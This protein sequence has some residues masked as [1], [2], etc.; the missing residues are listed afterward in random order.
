[1][2]PHVWHAWFTSVYTSSFAGAQS[3]IFQS[4]GGF[5]ESGHFDKYFVKKAQGKESIL[6]TLKTIPWTE[7]RTQRWIK[8]R[9]FFPKSGHCFRFSKKEPSRPPPSRPPSRSPVLS[10]LVFC[11]LVCCCNWICI[12]MLYSSLSSR[13]LLDV[14]SNWVNVFLF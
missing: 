6:D 11:I 13:Y 5:V 12:T 10:F 1:M 9:P 3:E 4:R 2:H 8:S 14:S 7:N